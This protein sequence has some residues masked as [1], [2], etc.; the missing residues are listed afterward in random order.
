MRPGHWSNAGPRCA[1][2]IGRCD[3]GRFYG[4][5][6]RVS[7]PGPRRACVATLRDG[8]M[9]GRAPPP[10]LTC[11]GVIHLTSA[12]LG[13][14]VSIPIH[15][16]GNCTRTHLDG[17]FSIASDLSTLVVVTFS[18]MIGL[19]KFLCP[20]S[21]PPRRRS[22]CERRR[23]VKTTLQDRKLN[24]S[25]GA[26]SQAQRA[27]R[28]CSARA[29]LNQV[30]SQL[31]C[32]GTAKRCGTQGSIAAAYSRAYGWRIGSLQHAVR[33]GVHVGAHCDQGR[34]MHHSA[35]AQNGGGQRRE[36][37]STPRP[38]HRRRQHRHV[39]SRR[40]LQFGAAR[41]VEVRSRSTR[42]SRARAALGAVRPRAPGAAAS[43]GG[44]EHMSQEL[45]LGRS[46]SARA[47]ASRAR[48]RSAQSCGQRI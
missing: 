48:A 22:C 33:Y 17:T 35:V 28:E 40:V 11:G 31:R 45:R 36:V 13:R 14:R 8:A 39:L 26:C 12:Q 30:P 15:V 29:G 41:R 2:G 32:A 21:S 23:L 46:L 44:A 3:V 19:H 1:P 25:A 27:Q 47:A 7:K 6:R 10:S 42:R 37:E 4:C 43:R 5:Y 16:V 24:D 34:A 9:V 20:G 18:I 38:H